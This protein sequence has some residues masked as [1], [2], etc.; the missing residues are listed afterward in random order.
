MRLVPDRVE[1][2]GAEEG[3]ERWTGDGTIHVGAIEVDVVADRDAG[4][5]WSVANRGD[6]PVAVDA[7]AL[8]HRVIDVAAPLRMFRNGYQSWSPTGIATFGVDRDPSLTAGAPALVIGM[9]HADTALAQ[10]GEL[11]SELFT[12]VLDA[13]SD[14]SAVLGFAGGWDHDGTFR[15]RAGERGPELWVEA[16]L[17]GAVLAPGEQRTLHACSVAAADDPFAALDAWAALVQS[18]GARTSAPFQVGWCSWYHYFHDVTEADIRHNLALAS[19]WPFSVFQVDDGY[20]HA[21]GD[22]LRTNERFPSPLS[23][24]ASAIAQGGYTPGIWIAPFVAALESDV[25]QAHPD[26]FARWPA[27]GRPLIGMVNPG[28]GGAVHTLD[29]TNPDV[30][31]HLERVARD[32]VAAGFPYLKLDFTYAPHLPGTYADP[33]RTP[34][35]RVR[36][37]YDAIRRGAGDDAFLLGCG[38]PLG[39]CIGVVDGMRIGADVAPWWHAS[40]DQWRPAGYER[41]EPAT[42]N[43]WRNTLTRSFLHRRLWLNDPDCVMLRTERTAMIPEAMRAWALA[44]GVSGGMALVSD[45][46][47]LLGRGSRALLDEVLELGRASDAEARAGT[48]ARCPDLLDASTPTRLSAA[49]VTL[50][51]D[52]D[53]GTAVLEQHLL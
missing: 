53:A 11:R 23:D 18:T 40:G 4:W 8:V 19:G 42:V 7:V 16:F 39:A 47:A 27:N 31:D 17:G 46:L 30:L 6:A 35:Q 5:T 3:A 37:G 26:W 29:T 38:A 15:L 10:P 34:A 52:P 36:A 28:W 33:S 20:Q 14:P 45:D 1:V 9:H 41:G 43:A 50:A 51:G 49:R 12:V 13:S 2:R 22:W 44:V 21:I 24:L 25:G 32:L 48:P